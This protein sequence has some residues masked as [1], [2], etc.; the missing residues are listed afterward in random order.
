MEIVGSE[1]TSYG[2]YHGVCLNF[3]VCMTQEEELFCAFMFMS[4]SV[5]L[6]VLAS[7]LVL[8]NKL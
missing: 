4:V 2:P 1:T 7:D 8:R 6:C 3:S 5:C